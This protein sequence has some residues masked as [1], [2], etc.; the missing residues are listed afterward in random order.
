MGWSARLYPYIQNVTRLAQR[1]P[2]LALPFDFVRP[3]AEG[4]DDFL[5]RSGIRTIDV[6]ARLSRVLI[7][8]RDRTCTPPA[9]LEFDLEAG[10]THVEQDASGNL[11]PR[12]G[13][14]LRR[15]ERSI[16]E[17]IE[18]MKAEHAYEPP[19]PMGILLSD[20][21]TMGE[22]VA[23]YEHM[24]SA[25]LFDGPRAWRL[26]RLEVMGEGQYQRLRGT[27]ELERSWQTLRPLFDLP[28]GRLLCETDHVYVCVRAADV[29]HDP[30]AH[31]VDDITGLPGPAC[32]RW[33]LDA[34]L[35]QISFVA[36]RLS[37]LLFRVLDGGPDVELPA[38]GTL[39]DLRDERSREDERREEERRRAMTPE[40][41]E[42]RERTCVADQ[43]G[44]AGPTRG[45]R[46]AAE[47]PAPYSESP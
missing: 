18:R 20:L 10:V 3:E 22:V 24:S 35:E 1:N 23:L 28:D 6:P 21:S 30:D 9:R 2:L 12:C 17:A 11:V 41:R 26:R 14:F 16:H 29:T 19:V 47:D 37:D 4:E 46:V 31:E 43:P 8:I 5:D 40:E 33:T 25:V 32:E 13:Y 34:G 42:Q 7:D 27:I 15:H 38:L 36:R 39:R 45:I 44:P